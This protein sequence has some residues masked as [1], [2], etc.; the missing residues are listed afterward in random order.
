MTTTANSLHNA[1]HRIP[2]VPQHD[3]S[4][5]ATTPHG[6]GRHPRLQHPVVRHESAPR[7]LVSW[8]NWI[9]KLVRRA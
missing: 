6:V 2:G 1:M 3:T 8:Q 4:R 5:N 7:V 9:A